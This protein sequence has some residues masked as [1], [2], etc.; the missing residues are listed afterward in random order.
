[1]NIVQHG[2]LEWKPR[3]CSTSTGHVIPRVL[4][5]KAGLRRYMWFAI[6]QVFGVYSVD[7]GL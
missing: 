3:W 4:V 2:Q 5:F 6:L 7:V 1:M